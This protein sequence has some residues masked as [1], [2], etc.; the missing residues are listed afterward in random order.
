VHDD[1][2]ASL[3]IASPINANGVPRWAI[4]EGEMLAAN[5]KIK[6]LKFCV[7]VEIARFKIKIL[8]EIAQ[9]P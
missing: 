3:E 9:Q 2:R 8:V 5:L 1:Q 6:F 7:W 4:P